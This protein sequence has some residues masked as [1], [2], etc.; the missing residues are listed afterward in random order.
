MEEKKAEKE[1]P[2]EKN[3][4]PITQATTTTNTTTTTTTESNN[5]TPAQVQT[6]NTTTT[7]PTTELT[8]SATESEPKRTNQV[9][10][11]ATVTASN[12]T[13]TGTTT[14]LKEV[15]KVE[16]KPLPNSNIQKNNHRGRQDQKGNMDREIFIKDVNDNISKEKIKEAFSKFGEV[17][18]VDIFRHNGFVEF[19][20]IE[21]AKNAIAAKNVIIDGHKILAEEKHKRKG[22][23][24]SYNNRNR[25]YRDSR[26]YQNGK[27]GSYVNRGK[28]IRSK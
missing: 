1:A 3:E 28:S 13:T 9:K 24:N 11:F 8:E 20:S 22:F 25:E 19:T 5:T 12:T 26:G 4:T 27:N 23:N 21:S 15:S 2:E 16:N 6:T 17:K 10:S 14:H 7:V 18:K